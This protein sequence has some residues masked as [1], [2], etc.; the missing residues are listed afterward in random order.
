MSEKMRYIRSLDGETEN[1][2]CAKTNPVMRAKKI[3]PEI[4]RQ[5]GQDTTK[6]VVGVGNDLFQMC[7]SVSLNFT[8]S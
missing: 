3:T 6:S 4:I 2:S 1:M 8:S 5:Q 7:I